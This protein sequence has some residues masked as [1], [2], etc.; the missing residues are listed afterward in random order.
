MHACAPPAWIQ[1]CAETP[2]GV[3]VIGFDVELVGQL[4]ID[5]LDDLSDDVDIAFDS[6]WQLLLLI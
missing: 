4:P 3:G 1:P 6:A 2:E 5:G